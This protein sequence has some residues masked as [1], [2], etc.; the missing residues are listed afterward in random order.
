MK[1]QNKIKIQRTYYEDCTIGRLWCGDFQ[2]FTLE[3]PLLN[4]ETNVSCIYPAGGYIGQRHFSP[5]NGD[6]IA[7]NNVM[8]RTNIQIHSGNYTSDILGCILVGDS[9]KFLNDDRIPDVTNSKNTLKKL[10]SILENSFSIEI[11]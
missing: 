2:C 4:N 8:G 1:K 7:I 5:K 9:V 6:C 11:L 10:L 3:L